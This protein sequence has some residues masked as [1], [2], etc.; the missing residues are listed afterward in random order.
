MGEH[1]W[2]PDSSLQLNKGNSQIR[3]TSEYFI[4]IT[5]GHE[6]SQDCYLL[7]VSNFGCFFPQHVLATVALVHLYL[8]LIHIDILKSTA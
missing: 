3:Y 2:R 6:N 8:W 7:F 1:N 4:A 5:H